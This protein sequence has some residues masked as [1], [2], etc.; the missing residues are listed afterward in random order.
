[1]VQTLSSLVAQKIVVL[2][3]Y[4]DPSGYQVGIMTNLEFLVLPSDHQGLVYCHFHKL[5]N[6]FFCVGKQLYS[7]A[8]L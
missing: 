8:F 6:G 1:M 5:H 4:G 2:I 7:F 3:T